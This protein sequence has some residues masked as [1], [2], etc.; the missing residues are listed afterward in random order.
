MKKPYKKGISINSSAYTRLGQAAFQQAFSEII[1]ALLASPEVFTDLPYSHEQLRQAA[2]ELM[3]LTL[4]AKDG[5]RSAQSS[6]NVMRETATIIL[7]RLALRVTTI[8]LLSGSALEG[9]RIIA[10]SKFT[11]SASDYK[12]RSFDSQ[13]V[14]NLKCNWTGNEGEAFACWKKIP[15]AVMYIAE[16]AFTN[17]A[18]EDT[19][20]HIA[21][22][23]S[24]R[25]MILKNLPAHSPCW[26]R[27]KALCGGHAHS[28]VPSNPVLVT[29]A[30]LQV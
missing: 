15:E 16:I 22:Q 4:A 24:R 30:P 23:T 26:V 12:K 29:N 5:S 20:W 3:E 13:P 1:Q 14:Q 17:P 18:D 6:R 9:K 25:K 11:A 7:N 28:N 10:L 19:V 27:L 8:A 21:G 2:A